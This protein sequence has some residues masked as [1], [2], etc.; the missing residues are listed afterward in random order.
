MHF[1][2]FSSCTVG[3]LLFL[4]GCVSSPVT[5]QRPAPRPLVQDLAMSGEPDSSTWKAPEGEI[6]LRDALLAGL[7]NSPELKA[8]SLEIRALEALA[9]QAGLMSN[10]NLG[11][12]LE[13]ILGSTRESRGF[14]SVETILEL[15][16]L[17]ELGGKRA[18]RRRVAEL[19]GELAAWDFEAKRLE[20]YTRIHESFLDVLA[21]Q[22]TLKLAERQ[23]E[24]AL[25]TKESVRRQVE[26]GKVSP[27][28]ETRAALDLSSRRVEVDL[29]RESLASA[30]RRLASRWGDANPTFERALGNLADPEP[31]P[32]WDSLAAMVDENISVAR[33]AVE[34]SR[35]GAELKLERKRRIPNLEVAVGVKHMNDT[36]DHAFV[37]GLSIPLMVYDRN[38]GAIEAARLRVEKAELEFEA[39]KRVV[40]RALVEAYGRLTEAQAAVKR[41]RDES[42]AA[43]EETLAAITEGYRLGKFDLLE[44]LDAQRSQFEVRQ[45]HQEAL[46][47]YHKARV[48]LEGILGR[49]IGSIDEIQ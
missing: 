44:T 46:A 49:S 14:R 34:M 42:L 21:A 47:N 10:P 11:L 32:F 25:K 3:W 36:D 16:Q 29:A 1:R 13:N 24:R 2:L 23:A 19:E 6:T 41:I 17:I 35:R 8:Y 12:E 20:V 33:W 15:S 48:Q 28:E 38:Q 40:L 9:L 27:I 26:T 30:R 45:Q 22:E 5:V 18:A 43:S 39:E 31:V 4:T 37:V 7:R